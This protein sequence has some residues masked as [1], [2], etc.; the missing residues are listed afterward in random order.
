MATLITRRALMTTPIA[1]CLKMQ[2]PVKGVHQDAAHLPASGNAVNDCRIV[3][4]NYHTQQWN[5]S[6]WS[7]SGFYCIAPGDLLT[8]LLMDIYTRYQVPP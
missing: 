3:T 8:L 1:D 2:Q 5:G 7:D 4:S 6:V